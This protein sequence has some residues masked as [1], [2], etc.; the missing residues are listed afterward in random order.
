METTGQISRFSFTK[1]RALYGRGFLYETPQAYARGLLWAVV[2]NKQA[3]V[4]NQPG[5]EHNQ[6]KIAL[7]NNQ[8]H[9]H[10]NQ[11]NA[12]GQFHFFAGNRFRRLAA[13]VKT[14]KR[15]QERQHEQN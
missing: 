8:P 3:P 11:H 6:L 7:Q 12:G 1:N 2:I 15:H 4:E 10:Y 14:N 5:P 13:Q 9:R